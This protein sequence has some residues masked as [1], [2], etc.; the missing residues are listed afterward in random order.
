MFTHEK[1]KASIRPLMMRL[2]GFTSVLVACAATYAAMA[3]LF[4]WTGVDL[5][6]SGAVVE[7]LLWVFGGT[8]G[9]YTAFHGVRAVEKSKGAA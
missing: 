6:T 4:P 9:A 5:E 1:K 7:N 3:P 8:G 2:T